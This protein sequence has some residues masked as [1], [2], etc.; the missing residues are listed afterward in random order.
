[1]EDELHF[2]AI[3]GNPALA[4]P[5]PTSGDHAFST[6]EWFH[7]AVTYNGDDG[8][9]DNLKFYWTR[10]GA[11]PTEANLIGTA[12]LDTDLSE[13]NLGE[14]AI[15]IHRRSEYR[16]PFFGRLDEVRI[17]DIAR[18]PAEF[19]FGGLVGDYNGNGELDAGDLDLQ[20]L[21][22]QK[23]VQDQDLAAYDLNGDNVVDFGDRQLWVEDPGFKN[24]WIGD[25]NL[26]LEF[27]SSDM[28][29]VFSK[30][31][32]E[33]QEA[34]TWEEGDWNGS[35]LFD[36]S[37]MVAA[38]AGGGYEKGLRTDAVAVPEPTGWLTLLIAALL[39][40]VRRRV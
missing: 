6:E 16:D 29:Q 1:V 15:T 14:T 27:N 25:A 17:S 32:Y 30:G 9:A 11:N 4:A 20:A 26:D 40:T 28:V 8:E 39:L 18:G 35:L 36:S 2:E 34:A 5:I 37:D 33:T 22:M 7:V 12:T 3:N 13:A 10:V 38:F 21:E 31:K 23:P 24:T 19:L